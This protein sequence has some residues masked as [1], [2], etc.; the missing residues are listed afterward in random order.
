MGVKRLG[1]LQVVTVRR[2]ALNSQ[3]GHIVSQL[4][5]E[6]LIC[7]FCRGFRVDRAPSH[8]LD[9]VPEQADAILVQR[10]AGKSF[11]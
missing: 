9:P 4:Q 8:V 1:A 6:G 5:V 11:V 2:F 7:L 3:S 10:S